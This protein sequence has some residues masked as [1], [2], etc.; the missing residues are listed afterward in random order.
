V[1]AA[2]ANTWEPVNPP[3]QAIDGNLATRWSGEGF[4][5]YLELALGAGRP[6]CATRVAWHRGNLRWNDFT[7]YVSSD[8]MAYTKVWEGRSSGTTAD[9]ET[10]R[11]TTPHGGQ[12][13]IA[14]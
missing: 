1:S 11:F 3:V 13:T 9:F 8:G 12:P 10:Y 2:T 6:L 4:G 7:V 5:A 14:G